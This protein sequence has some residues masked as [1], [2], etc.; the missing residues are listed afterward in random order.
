MSWQVS[1]VL[2]VRDVRA[3]VAYYREKLGFDCPDESIYD[4]IGDEGAIYAI[5]RRSDAAIHLGRAR[6]GHTI[7]P[8][9]P[10]NSLGAYLYVPEVKELFAEFQKRGAEIVQEP[11]VAPY[12]FEE[13]VVRDPDGYHITFG[14]DP[15]G[16]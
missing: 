12:G 16:A 11:R 4:G 1:P 8:G 15:A 13:V 2:R 6:T 5:M 10:P 3:A 14:A 9:Q 7:D